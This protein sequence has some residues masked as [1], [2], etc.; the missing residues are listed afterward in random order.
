[1]PP[2]INRRRQGKGRKRGAQAA[3]VD[4]Q[5]VSTHHSAARADVL[6]VPDDLTRRPRNWLLTETPPKNFASMPH[7][8]QDSY[9]TTISISNSAPTYYGLAF[10]LNAFNA[11]NNMVSYWDQY[12]IYSAVVRL[13]TGYV[14]AQPFS[15]GEV[16]TCLDFDNITSLGSYQSYL[17]YSSADEA[18]IMPG[19]SIER[20]LKPTVTT[21]VYNGSIATA[22]GLARTWIDSGSSAIPHYGFRAAFQNNGLSGAAMVVSV[23]I[24][25]GFRNSI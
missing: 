5:F 24:I 22:Y 15:L 18:V 20:F 1:M 6:T 10:L 7:W 4:K 11:L 23:T 12:C 8:V 2:R 16:V 19:K 14:G 21:E 13:Y 9:E 25:A 3:A 17:D